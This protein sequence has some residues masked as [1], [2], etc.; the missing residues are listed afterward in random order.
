[1]EQ[2][3]FKLAKRGKRRMPMDYTLEEIYKEY[4]AEHKRDGFNIDKKTF[5]KI[6][7]YFNKRAIDLI[8]DKSR[9]LELPYRLGNIRIKKTMAYSKKKKINWAL[10]NKCKKLIYH[11]NEHSAGYH[12]KFHWSKIGCNAVNKSA[13]SYKSGRINERR[14]AKI[15]LTKKT[16]YFL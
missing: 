15:I 9:T 11:L 2:E 1:M 6:A 5:V 10:S 13:Y 8:L 12:Y 16:E 14:L 7:V 3:K 4:K